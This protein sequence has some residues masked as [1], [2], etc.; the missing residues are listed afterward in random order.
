MSRVIVNL[1]TAIQLCIQPDRIPYAKYLALET[2]VDYIVAEDIIAGINMPGFVRSL[3]D[4]YALHRDTIN[5]NTPTKKLRIAGDIAAGQPATVP[6]SP[7]IC[8]RVMTGAQVPLGTAAVIKQEQAVR[9]QDYI[10]YKDYVKDNENLQLAGDII[11]A[12]DKIAC[13]GSRLT[14]ETLEQIACA[15]ISHVPVFEKPRVYIIV[16]GAELDE[17]GQPLSAG[18]IYNS[19]RTL[20]ST[21]IT[22]AGGQPESSELATVDDLP[23]LMQEI[24]AAVHNAPLVI[25][26]G[27]TSDGQYDI[28]PKA[29]EK[30]GAR[31]LFRELDLRPAHRTSAAVLDESIVFNVTGN[32]FGGVIIFYALISPVF[33]W[34]QG[35]RNYANSWFDFKLDY[36]LPRI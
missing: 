32:P 7:D 19:N 23:A 34:L 22:K 2:A 18:H 13:A 26:S 17:P 20:F 28:V 33:K 30:L 24:N 11:T 31:F 35:M 12:G 9:Q 4:G 6:L 10:F 5:L 29:L 3:V 15:G 36:D 25:I 14:P 1:E 8:F 16:T 21:L 27:G